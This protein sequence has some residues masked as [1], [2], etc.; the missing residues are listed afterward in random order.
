M[1]RGL[2]VVY[3]SPPDVPWSMS[4]KSLTSS[5]KIG[6]LVHLDMSGK[7]GTGLNLNTCLA[8]TQ[9]RSTEFRILFFFLKQKWINRL[10]ELQPC[11]V[12]QNKW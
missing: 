8:V 7:Y 5:E 9:I 12:A 6:P 11:K 3:K 4:G 10:N 1:C 2:S